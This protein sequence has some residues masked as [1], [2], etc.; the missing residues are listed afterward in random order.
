MLRKYDHSPHAP[1]QTLVELDGPH[2]MSWARVNLMRVGRVP[3]W[4]HWSILT[5]AKN[6]P[7]TA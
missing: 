2:L 1:S 4:V 5:S 7:I 3:K 6:W